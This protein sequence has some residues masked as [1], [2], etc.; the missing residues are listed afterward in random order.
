MTRS[1]SIKWL[2]RVVLFSAFLGISANSEARCCRL[3]QTSFGYV[4]LPHRDVKTGVK[5]GEEVGRVARSLLGLATLRFAIVDAAHSKYHWSETA[6]DGLPV[7]PW[8]FVHGVDYLA[9]QPPNSVLPHEIG[10]DLLRR[11]VIPD[12]HPGQYGTD[13]PDWLD[14]AVAIAFEPAED[15]TQRRC[16]AS[17]L[18][19]ERALIP[20]GRFLTMTHPDLA[21]R[22]S[23]PA[24]L[25]A[26]TLTLDS[27]TSR[28]TPAFYAMSMAFPEYVA[29]RTQSASAFADMIRAYRDGRPM[30]KR[31]AWKVRRG[32]EHA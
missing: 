21:K 27:S 18:L 7:Y 30:A 25:R 12:S 9:T 20:L 1:S 28:D 26:T 3:T 23:A 24:G 5:V 22:R 13:A 32:A 15:Q 17:T 11:Y 14:E 31:A 8:Y 19:Q 6:P 16:E 4:S 29:A 10:H 2:G